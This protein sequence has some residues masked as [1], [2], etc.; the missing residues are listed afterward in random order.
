MSI[1]QSIMS[2]FG[3]GQ[4]APAAQPNPA[5]AQ[6]HTQNPQPATPGQQNQPNPAGDPGLPAEGLDKFADLFKPLTPEQAAQQPNFN[7]ESLFAS[8][9]PAKVAEIAKGLNFTDGLT[10]DTLAAIGNGGE[11]A[12]QA[13]A[14]ALNQVGQKSFTQALLASAEVSKQAFIQANGSLDTRL[15]SATRNQAV[16]S[17]I[18][19]ENPALNS[20]A[21]KPIVDAL[22]QA[23]SLKNP[24]ATPQQIQASVKEYL[25]QFAAVAGGQQ[26]QQEAAQEQTTDW[27]KL[28]GLG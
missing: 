3:G 4:Q 6:Q 23:I 11:G 20:P 21:A 10:Q 9:E 14:A 7:P 17:A 25:S 19:A 18:Y 28:F 15:N 22:Q 16:A 5:P 1:G 12:M 8:L 27:A 2:I 24:T 26:Q 13:F